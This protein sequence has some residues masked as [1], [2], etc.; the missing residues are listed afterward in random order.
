LVLK[1]I[2]LANFNYI[3]AHK[4][5]FKYNELNLESYDYMQ[6]LYLDS[7]RDDR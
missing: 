2:E 4:I 1:L 5:G 3:G 6:R 7:I